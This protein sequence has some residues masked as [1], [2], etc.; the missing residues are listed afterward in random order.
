MK[1]YWFA[2]EDVDAPYES[3]DGDWVKF[4]DVQSLRNLFYRAV[5]E[6]AYVQAI[7][8]EYVSRKHQ[9]LVASSEGAEIIDQGMK[10]LGVKDLSKDEL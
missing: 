4:S 8:C 2:I 1:R 7:S 10:L 3:E 5:K 6:L 9:D